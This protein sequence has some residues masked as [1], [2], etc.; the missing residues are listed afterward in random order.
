VSV[1]EFWHLVSFDNGRLMFSVSQSRGVYTVYIAWW[2]Q[3]TNVC[4]KYVSEDNKKGKKVEKELFFMK[5]VNVV[6]VHGEFDSDENGVK[7]LLSILH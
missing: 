7:C 3:F 2:T 6:R 4:T 5:T 1:K